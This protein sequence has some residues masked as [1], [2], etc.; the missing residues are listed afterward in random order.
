M[1]MRRC[2]DR[3]SAVRNAHHVDKERPRPAPTAR[4]NEYLIKPVSAKAITT[5]SAFAEAVVG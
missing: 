2:G 3:G 5:V 4:V 1:T